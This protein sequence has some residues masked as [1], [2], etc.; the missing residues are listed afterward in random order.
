MNTNK[1]TARSL[2]KAKIVDLPVRFGRRA[3]LHIKQ[4]IERGDFIQLDEKL[5]NRRI[6]VIFREHLA[7]VNGKG[8]VSWY[9]KNFNACNTPALL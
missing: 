1:L 7:V 9:D 2:A 5:I 6:K 3:R 4:L 8:D